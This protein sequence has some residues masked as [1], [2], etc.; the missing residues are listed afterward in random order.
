MN[1]SVDFTTIKAQVKAVSVSNAAA[2]VRTT[3]PCNIPSSV[4]SPGAKAHWYKGRFLLDIFP[5]L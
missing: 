1:I 3:L 4:S 2:A 5:I